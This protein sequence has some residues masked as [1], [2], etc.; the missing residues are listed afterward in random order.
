MPYEFQYYPAYK[1]T[2]GG[3]QVLVNDA[4]EDDPTYLEHHP[5]DPTKTIQPQTK[6]PFTPAEMRDLLTAGKIDFN[7]DAE[8]GLLTNGLL[9]AASTMGLGVPTGASAEEIYAIMLASGK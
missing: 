9:T 8:P 6:A 1:W 2:P 7:P 5:D 3:V 4:T